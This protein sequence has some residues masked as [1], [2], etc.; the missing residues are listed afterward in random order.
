MHWCSFLGP[1]RTHR[2]PIGVAPDAGAAAG[3]ARGSRAEGGR[4]AERTEGGRERAMR[5]PTDRPTDGATATSSFGGSALSTPLLLLAGAADGVSFL[6]S[7]LSAESGVRHPSK[8]PIQTTSTSTCS[9]FCVS[10]SS[11][12]FPGKGRRSDPFAGLRIVT[13]AGDAT[14]REDHWKSDKGKIEIWKVATVQH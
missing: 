12:D 1:A 3:G 5:R 13:G 7:R 4:K 11:G 10:I 2:R 6:I 14:R 9:S 8:V